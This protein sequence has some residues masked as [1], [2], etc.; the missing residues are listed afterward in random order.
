MTI[1]MNVKRMK[2]ALLFLPLLASSCTSKMDE[3]YELPE[4]LKGNTWEV[5]EKKGNYSL[6][7][8]GVEKSGY[9]DLM[10]G[11]GILT[12]MAPDDAAFKSYLQ[13]NGYQS[14]ADMPAPELKKLI[15]F[16]LLYYSFSKERFEN[17][18]PN[19]IDTES[20]GSEGLFFKFRTKSSDGI[21]V[22]NW[23]DGTP[24]NVY[25]KEHFLPVF[26]HNIFKTKKIDAK[27]NYEFFFPNS[28]WS[29]DNGFNVSNASVK[30]N[31]YSVISD[32]GYIYEIDRVLQPLETVHQVMEKNE[33]YSLFL[34]AYDRF[35]I[36]SF[37]NEL[38]INYGKGDSLFVW[39]HTS[40]PSIASEWTAQDYYLLEMLSGNAVNVY[41]PDNKALMEFYDT[42]WSGEDGFTSL[43]EVSFLPLSLVMKNHTYAGTLTFPEELEKGT[44]KTSFG[45]TIRFNREESQNPQI[46]SNGSFYGMKKTMVPNFFT[47]VSGPMLMSPKYNMFSR[48]ADNAGLLYSM[49]SDAVRY[50]LFLP[51]D[52]TLLHYTQVE[53]KSLNYANT[54]PLIPFSDAVQIE[55]DGDV[56]WV[57]M[58]NSRCN[59]FVRNHLT[60]ESPISDMGDE[61][62]YKTYNGFE[63]LYRQGDNIYSSYMYNSGLK[64]QVIQ[65]V[66]RELSNGAAYKLVG[67][68]ASALVSETMLFKNFIAGTQVTNAH[69]FYYCWAMQKTAGF[70]NT[71]PAFNFMQGERF[72]ALIPNRAAIVAGNKDI[73][74]TAAAAA[75]FWK[76]YYVNVN[77][78][79]LTDYPFAGTG[80]DKSLSTFK[81]S[82]GKAAELR[83]TDNNGVLQITD[84][85]GNTVNVVGYF[86]NIY[87]DG[88]AYI[89]DGI[90]KAE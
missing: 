83:F 68:E 86:P 58:S 1:H 34:K 77:G 75:E 39:E 15:T 81:T 4:W 89:I 33:D 43:D 88:A 32:N 21:E 46:C 71:V 44:F 35:T 52:N 38:S 55:G 66:D 47:C 20:A 42:Y 14:V 65:K 27:S 8:E 16:H 5:L 53:S 82:N 57:N 6:F 45:S 74:K 7:L 63:Y 73:P 84:A 3:Y 29:G 48:M 25:H 67:E 87:A 36:F 49:T 90:L 28:T 79:G 22:R 56:L 26:S 69:P 80:F 37:D 30:E 41:A 50:N 70:H 11:K 54:T 40:L 78:S 24:R 60:V 51:E 59:S 13:D 19:G 61:K 2:M 18:Q 17:Y 23:L 64:P 76:Y 62:I 12:V 31:G 72:I 9:T 10:K 85:T